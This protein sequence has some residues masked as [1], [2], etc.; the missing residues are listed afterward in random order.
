MT[1]T[2]DAHVAFAAAGIATGF[3]GCGTSD[4]QTECDC[5]SPTVLVDVPP[6]R[7]GDVASVTLSGRACPTAVAT[8]AASAA[9]GCTEYAFEATGDGEC[10]LDVEFTT[11]PADFTEALDFAQVRCCPGYYVQPATG[12]PVSVPDATDAGASE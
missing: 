11:A 10:D 6:D 9:S 12:S 3:A 4:A 8:C 7:A 5:A 1:A 2:Q